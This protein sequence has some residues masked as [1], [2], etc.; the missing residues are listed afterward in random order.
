MNYLGYIYPALNTAMSYLLKKE[1][2]KPALEYL[3][4][5]I[6]KRPPRNINDQQ[7]AQKLLGDCYN[8]LRRYELAEKYFLEMVRLG[9]EPTKGFVTIT[10]DISNFIMGHFY[11]NR[12]NYVKACF[13]LEQ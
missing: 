3:Q 1:D 11:F 6:V 10:K 8:M 5:Q 7:I 12:G 4:A 13:Y 2:P 9:N